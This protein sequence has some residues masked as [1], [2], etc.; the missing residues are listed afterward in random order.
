M[1][2]SGLI[3][4]VVLLVTAAPVRAA[5]DWPKWLGPQ[6]TGISPET[7]LAQ[8]WPRLG[9]KQVW[10]KKVGVGHSS[11]VA[12]D[13]KVYLFH[14]ANGRDHLTCFDAETGKVI[15]DQKYNNGWT[16]AYKGTRA[17]PTIEKEDNRVY[18][19]GGAGN[20]V[21]WELDSGKL[22]WALDVLKA[23]GSRPLQWGQAGSPLIVED[24]I[25]VQGGEGGHLCLA[26]DK[27]SGRALWQSQARDKGGYAHIIQVEVNDKPQLIVFGGKAVYGINPRD[28]RTLWQEPWQT[29]YD[30]NAATPVYRDEHLFVSSEYGHGSMMLRLGGLGA[31]KLWEKK[32]IQC[33]FQPPILDGDYLYA[34]SSGTLKCMSWPDGKVVW[35]ARDR[36]LRLGPGGS[37]VRVGDKLI[38]LSEQGKLSLVAAGPDG[39]KLLE[40]AELFDGSE[41]WSTP[42]VYG[43]KLYAKGVNELVCVDLSAN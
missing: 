1:R 27:R 31:R 43:G 15:W 32:D 14:L 9:P 25:F 40:Q 16:G 11:P 5:E 23:T 3:T 39:V 8:Q 33:K 36:N 28:G 26:V 21:C 29:S 41:I 34:N 20:L 22:K 7:G 30:V 18:T 6:G 12:V 13:G 38:T 4:A 24:R 19:L 17:T 2:S 42:L 35:E 10:A 37:M